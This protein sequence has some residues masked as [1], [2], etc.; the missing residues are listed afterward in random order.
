MENPISY[1]AGIDNADRLRSEAQSLGVTIEK[2]RTQAFADGS[3]AIQFTV[4]A[5]DVRGFLVP[6]SPKARQ[7][8]IDCGR[9]LGPYSF[10]RI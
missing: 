4:H 2:E 3:S 6:V 10:V 1:L 7:R 9:Y 8:Q 5:G